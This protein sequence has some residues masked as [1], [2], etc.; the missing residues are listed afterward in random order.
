VSLDLSSIENYLS[1]CRDLAR[2]KFASYR[3]ITD[4]ARAE[5]EINRYPGL[6]SLVFPRHIRILEDLVSQDELK[7]QVRNVLDGKVLW[8][9]TCA[10]E[11]TRLGLGAKY[12]IIPSRH[13]N[14]MFMGRDAEIRQPLTVRPEQLNHLNLG[15]RHMLQLA[16]NIRQLALSLSYDCKL[17][18][19]KQYL[20]I[21]VNQHS[22]WEIVEDF[23]RARFYG[24]SPE[25]VLF[26]MQ[27]SF[28][29][30]KP[31]R[32]G[33]WQID[34]SSPCRLHNHGQMVMQTTMDGQ[35][36]TLPDRRNPVYLRW[37][38]YL[39]VLEAMTDKVSFN[40][41]DL[42]YLDSPLDILSLAACANLGRQGYQM[43]MEVVMNDP[44]APIKGG[45]C[46]Y[47]QNL[48]RDVII[49]SFQLSGVEP[50]DITCLN[51][52]VNHYPN[53][54]QAI[55]K[56]KAKGLPMP[57]TVKEENLYFQPVQ[58]DINFLVPTAF[59]RRHDLSPIR[60]WKS[61][62]NTPQALEFMLRQELRPGFLKWAGELTGLI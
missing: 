6:E 47:D 40:I 51:K 3:N 49:E 54:G 2:Q 4:L 1:S 7:A 25:R 44:L 11:A 16:W 45:A 20:L 19:A 28:P 41:E 31:D 37:E 26:M 30:L 36:F 34:E 57:I 53:P 58:G 9:H 29:G 55:K 38:E 15:Q 42:D 56:V 35:I 14:S 13:L 17:A 60:S 43:V 59:V 32:A 27:H 22:G 46:Y 8:E 48:G 50:K 61:G 39:A 21:T 10:G 33:V 52:N 12:L 62:R 24:F 18:L 5:R 23:V